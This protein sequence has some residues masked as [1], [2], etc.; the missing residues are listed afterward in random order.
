MKSLISYGHFLFF[1]F[2]LIFGFSFQSS[3]SD[4]PGKTFEEIFDLIYKQQFSAAQFRLEGSRDSLDKWEYQVLDLDLL[5]WEALSGNNKNSY[6]QFEMRLKS[7]NSGLRKKDNDYLLEEMIVSCY[8]FR[9]QVIKERPI[10]MMVILLRINQIIQQIEVEILNPDQ[11]E[12][13]KIFLALYNIGKSK[14]LLN[15]SNL[16]EDSIHTLESCLDSSNP[17]FRTA[18]RYLLLKIY[19]EMEHSPAKARIYCEQLCSTYPTNKIF[20][21][22]LELCI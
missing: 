8:S 19:L 14:L 3:A 9:L 4:K 2:L 22:I 21:S 12:V 11:Q 13:Y 16:T 7:Y 18:A 10:A 15:N 1:L 5:F 17:V 20:L 6:D